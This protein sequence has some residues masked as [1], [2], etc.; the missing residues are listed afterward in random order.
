MTASA[1][2]L[3]AQMLALA[4][5][6]SADLTALGISPDQ[7]PLIGGD[8][9]ELEKRIQL[10][11]LRVQVIVTPSNPDLEF[12]QLVQRYL[13][14]G[15]SNEL[16]SRVLGLSRREIDIERQAMGLVGRVGRR[17]MPDE[18]E[19]DDLVQLWNRLSAIPRAARYLAVWE[20]YPT[21]S[22]AAIHACLVQAGAVHV[23]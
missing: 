21:H 9:S 19:R 8:A 2:R 11:E 23:A 1:A 14:A 13:R 15:A 3:S 10:G 22:L 12:K 4:A 16:M 17:L 6:S 5:D 18:M 20:H 7:L